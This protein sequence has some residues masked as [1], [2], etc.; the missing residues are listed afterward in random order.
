MTLEQALDKALSGS[1][2]NWVRV[3]PTTISISKQ[4]RATKPPKGKAKAPSA[5]EQQAS[6][7][8]EVRELEKLVVV[9]SRLGTSPVESALPI[10]VITRD[11][12]D[13]SG[14]GNIAQ[15]LS[16]LSEVSI[17]NVGDRNIG[18]GD[19]VM[20]GGN[21]MIGRAHVCTSVNNA[22]LVCLLLLEKK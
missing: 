19:G 7:R 12:I 8:H 16:Y 9:G 20:D 10:K 4:P 22:H 18:V 11:Q 6:E 5:Q 14:V 21:T 17:N 2:L 3:S 13:R 1:G 15:V